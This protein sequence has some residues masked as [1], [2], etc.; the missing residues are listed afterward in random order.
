M[1]RLY[2]KGLSLV[3][4]LF[5]CITLTGQKN[6]IKKIKS[7][8]QGLIEREDFE[9]AS[10]QLNDAIKN[11]P[12]D[13]ELNLLLG[14]TLLSMDGHEKEAVEQL[15]I[16]RDAFKMKQKKNDNAIKARFYLGQA[17]HLNYQFDEANKIL[18]KLKS[19]VPSKQNELLFQ[20]EKELRYNNNAIEL[21]KNPVKF[22]IT[23]LGS[24]INTPY[25]EH[26]PVVSADEEMLV[27]T[28]NREGTGD[29][30][31]PDGLFYEDIYVSHYRSKSW[32]P[33]QN[34][35]SYINT[36]GNN[37]TIS[38]S[39]DGKTLFVYMHDGVSGDIYKSEMT[40][41]GWTVPEKFPKPINSQY[42]ETHASITL[43]ESIIFFSSDRPGG[44]GGK[45]IYMSR[46]L[47]NGEWGKEI[48]LGSEI[49]TEG[50]EESPFI[51]L[52]GKTLYF[53]STE[54]NSMGGYDIFKTELTDS[55][56]W[57]NPVNIG[58]P[59]NT[60]DDDLFY[61]PTA[62]EQR[63]YF[64][65]RRAGGEGRSDIY[66]IEFDESDPRSLGVVAGY[67]FDENKKPYGN[68]TI[69]LTDNRTGELLGYYRPNPVTGKYVM[70][71]PAGNSYEAKYQITYKTTD[72][73]I[74][75]TFDL[76]GRGSYGSG[77]WAT[78]LDA[79]VIGADN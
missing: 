79:I 40:F 26:S 24:T 32:T 50:D 3:V 18:E 25:D 20:I 74:V 16:A 27:F 68:V 48:N 35:G 72:E 8:V 15:E 66:L 44:F 1:K 7:N 52:D 33:A 51:H 5:V 67:I 49:N 47:P 28:S 78:Y 31:T 64:A 22:K 42:S 54:H 30:K 71:I 37:A 29:T 4:L 63:V 36:E 58:Y 56:T 38:I 45:D 43:D 6:D 17:Y 34:V 75:K 65:S 12:N 46:K 62:N 19:D 10:V 2:F 76:S 11:N 9:N 53:C 23:N 59:I 61:I 70:I 57:S 73:T 14:I 41:D 69:T 55:A 13:K 21:K 77:N 60:P 39:A